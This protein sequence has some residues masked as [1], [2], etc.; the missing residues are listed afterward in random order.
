MLRGLV[1]LCIFQDYVQFQFTVRE[2]VTFGDIRHADDARRLAEA[3][4]RAD[5]ER[6]VERLSKGVETPLGRMFDEG[7]ELSMGQWQRIALARLF[8]SQAPILLFDEPTAWM[9]PA[10]RQH[11]AQSIE[12]IKQDRI[13]FLIRHLED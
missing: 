9:D 5:A 4:R 11:F 2:N 7:E 1:F 12:A 3:L 10:A 6:V 13:V 8:Y